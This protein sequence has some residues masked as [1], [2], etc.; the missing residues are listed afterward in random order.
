MCKGGKKKLSTNSQF[1]R[2]KL[3]QRFE[4][5]KEYPKSQKDIAVHRYHNPKF[6]CLIIIKSSYIY[7]YK[8]MKREQNQ[9]YKRT[10]IMIQILLYKKNTIIYN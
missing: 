4:G 3:F 8:D 1:F 2:F 5:K 6:I 9:R 7:I 10:S